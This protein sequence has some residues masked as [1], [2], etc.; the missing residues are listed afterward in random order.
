MVFA[1]HF[2]KDVGVL[3]S[4]IVPG[5]EDASLLVGFFLAGNDGILDVEIPGEFEEGVYLVVATSAATVPL[6]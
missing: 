1:F 2:R 6:P 3:L 4:G 5:A